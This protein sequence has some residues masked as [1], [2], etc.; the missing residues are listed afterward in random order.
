MFPIQLSS[1]L[2]AAVVLVSQLME[3][4]SLLHLEKSLLHSFLAPT[5]SELHLMVS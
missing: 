4:V 5:S 3:E 2:Y 1:R